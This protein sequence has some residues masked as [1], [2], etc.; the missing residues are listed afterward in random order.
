MVMSEKYSVLGLQI[1]G[2]LVKYNYEF[3]GSIIGDLFNLLAPIILNV[4]NEDPCVAATE[5]W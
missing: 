4:N 1:L 3:M 2:E 5:V